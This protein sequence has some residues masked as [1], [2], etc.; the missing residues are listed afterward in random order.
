MRLTATKPDKAVT[1]G[2][3]VDAAWDHAKAVELENKNLRLMLKANKESFD[4]QFGRT[5]RLERGIRDIIEEHSE[6]NT[7]L[8]RDLEKLLLGD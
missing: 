2:L 6:A 7:S 4:K 1:D 3:L 5:T 8:R